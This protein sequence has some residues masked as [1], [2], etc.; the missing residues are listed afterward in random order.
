MELIS[1]DEAGRL[2]YHH[3][4]ALGGK[5]GWLEIIK[6]KGVGSSKFIYD[7]GIPT[8]DQ[9]SK[10]SNALDYVSLELLKKGI[11]IR[12][13]KKNIFRACIFSF[14]EIQKINITTYR[15]KIHTRRGTKIV[16]QADV[17]F[18]LKTSKI[19]L[20]LTPSFYKSGISFFNKP[21]LKEFSTFILHPKLMDENDI[22]ISS[23]FSLI[24]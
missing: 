1:L 24:R 2:S 16:K 17:D 15:F 22:D 4:K 23:Y 10:V 19:R 11:V 9:I 5:F 20:K 3:L 12:F 18:H 8:F 13:Q 14:D 7:S 21:K 6:L